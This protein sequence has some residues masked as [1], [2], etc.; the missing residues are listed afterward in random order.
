MNIQIKTVHFTAD[1]KLVDFVNK[2]VPKLDTYFEGI[3]GAEVILKVIKPETSNNKVAELKLS[4]PGS[5]Y[6]FA[7]KQADSFE[8]A[9]D[10]C[11]DAIRKQLAKFKEKQ[12]DK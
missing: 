11:I 4:I 12:K 1:Q 10:L 8:E 5:D 9:I 3:I 7:E 2:K 6:L